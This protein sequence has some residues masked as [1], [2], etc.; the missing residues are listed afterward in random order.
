MGRWLRL[1]LAV[2]LVASGLVAIPT[3]IQTASASGSPSLTVTRTVPGNT[4][5]GETI[6]VTLSATNPGPVNGYNLSFTDIIPNGVDLSTISPAPDLIGT[7]SPRVAVWRN[8]HDLLAGT[9]QTFAYSYS[10]LASVPVSTVVAGSASAYVNSNERVVPEFD[11][12]GAVDSSTST[13]SGVSTTTSTTLVP[14]TITKS[15]PSPESELLRGIRDH[16]TAYTLTLKNNR[17][18]VSTG[19]TITDYLPAG[20]EFLGCS[21][22]DNSS[23]GI[24][25]YPGSGPITGG[26]PA[27]SNCLP[28]GASLSATTVQL[29]PDG[30]GPLPN[31]VYTR[32]EWSSLGDMA[33]GATLTIQYAAAIPLRENALPDPSGGA[34]ANLDNNTGPLTSDEEPL[35]NFVTAQAS[36]QGLVYTAS[37]T[38]QVTAEDLALQKTVQPSQVQQGQISTWTLQYRTSEYASNVGAVTFTD[39]LPDGLEY[40]DTVSGAGAPATTIQPNHTQTVVWTLSSAP[41]PNGTGSIVF[42]TTTLTNYRAGGPVAAGDSWT[43]TAN[44]SAPMDVVGAGRPTVGDQS[45]ADQTEVG[46]TVH[47]QVASRASITGGACGNGSGVSWLDNLATG[48]RPGD[49]V[50]F[51]IDVTF[52]GG[53]DTLTPIVRDVLPP[54]FSYVSSTAGPNSTVTPTSV[55]TSDP[56]AVEW[57]LP[58]VHGANTFEMIVTSVVD[59]VSA[60][61]SGADETNLVKVRYLDTSGQLYSLRDSAGVALERPVLHLTKTVD[62]GSS[63]TLIPPETAAF[64]VT[65]TNDG[66][67]AAV[68]ATVRDNLPSDWTCAD[69]VI[70]GA[71]C[72]SGVI[73]WSIASLAAHSS[74]ALDYTGTVPVTATHLDTLT[75]TAGVRDYFAATNNPAAPIMR[76]VPRNN[77][78]PSIESLANSDPAIDS[79]T[80][81]VGGLTVVKD[82]VTS[83][84]SPGNGI[85]DATIGEQVTY[86]I[87]T[88]L[89]PGL[90]LYGPATVRDIVPGGIAINATSFSINGTPGVTIVAGQTVN[91]RIVQAGSTWV[92]PPGSPDDVFVLTITGTVIDNSTNTIGTTLDNTASL[93]F[94][95]AHGTQRSVTSANAPVTIVEPQLSL[96]KSDNAGGQALPGAQVL[97]TLT[98]SN[99][100]ATSSVKSSTAYDSVVTDVVP[101]GLTPLNTASLPAG[102]G[103]T[104]LG[105]SGIWQPSNRTITF[106]N[107][108]IAPGASAQEQYTVRVDDPILSNNTLTNNAKIV[109]SSLPGSVTGERVG[110]TAN[111]QLGSGYVA[112]A[113]DTL[114]A[115]QIGVTKTADRASATIGE[116]V[117]Y[118]VTATVPANTYAPDTTL[119]DTLPSGMA[120]RSL[121]A[122]SCVDSLGA[123]CSPTISVTAP[124]GTTTN[125]VVFWVGD[126]AAQSRARTIT[127]SYTA[128]VGTSAHRPDVETNTVV[129]RFNGTNKLND[130]SL[131]GSAPNPST[132]D[133]TGN[134]ASSSVTVV[135][136][137]LVIDKNVAG[138]IGDSDTRRAKPGDPLD[139]TV[140]VTNAGTSTA[141][142]A[143]VVDTLPHQ[144]PTAISCSSDVSAITGGGSCTGGANPTISWTISSL[145]A[146]ASTSFS[147]RVT[148][149]VGWTSAQANLSGAELVNSADVTG[150]DGVPSANQLPGIGYRHYDDVTPDTVSI[151]LDLASISGTIWEDWTRNDALDP[152]DPRLAGVAVTVTYLGADG[153]PGGGDDEV[154]STVTGAGGSYSVDHLPAGNYRVSVAP[155]SLPIAGL[156]PSYDADGVSTANLWSG[157]LAE[158]EDKQHIDF[159]Y[160][161]SGSIGDAVYLD[162]NGNGFQGPRD[163]G[164]PGVGVQLVWHAPGGDLSESTTTDASGHY[165]FAN[166]PAGSYS[167]SVD[168]S[169]VPTHLTALQGAAGYQLTLPTAF[170]FLNADFGY[171]GSNT[172]GDQVFLDSNGDGVQGPSEPGIPG[173]TVTLVWAGADGQLS[174]GLDNVTFTT[175]TD[176]AG[177]YLFTGLPDGTFKVTVSG[178]PA[179]LQNTADPDGGGDSTA[180][181]SVSLGQARLDQDFGYRG[182]ASVGD[183]VWLDLSADGVGQTGA[184]GLPGIP[185]SVR[186]AGADGILGTADDIVTTATTDADGH[187]LAE[188]LPAS[189]T[190]VS[191]PASSL[192]SGI[193][194]SRDLDGGDPASTQLGLASGES[195]RD[196]DFVAV[197]RSTLHGVVWNDVDANAHRGGGEPGIAGVTVTA[198]WHGPNSSITMTGVS[199]ADG[200]WSFPAVPAGSWTVSYVPSTAPAGL[201]PTT[202]APVTV[203]VP[204]LGSGYAQFGLSARQLPGQGVQGI[205]TSLT[206]AIA[207][208]VLGLGLVLV[209]RHRRRG[210]GGN[211]E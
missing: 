185:V 11:A 54:S 70:T 175:V 145:A 188:G 28:T 25:D 109:T 17:F 85:T 86:T 55:D 105:G 167:V 118:T 74:V 176:A 50:C 62:G 120:F 68:N 111:A 53:V 47:K 67:V 16:K 59:R 43:N 98:A 144:A 27:L 58:T 209:A 159:A 48:Y 76:Y 12:T 71:S 207:L 40:L 84:T 177:G 129:L 149:P 88:R 154:Y 66:D 152:S 166:M 189:Q 127:F 36:Y 31:S 89:G 106:N 197:G 38:E 18:G 73:T 155:S 15:E 137:T 178:V 33:A 141:Y 179:G 132:F 184:P 49:I 108:S 5:L 119:F 182:T 201:K 150:Y 32:V 143:T 92:N 196:V 139:Y 44:V 22:A 61:A 94:Y 136:P 122:S 195:R 192:P 170:N 161:G 9:T 4:L 125:P 34:T 169:T 57:A 115:P 172:I 180:Q 72:S 60:A 101:A 163:P 6:T 187:Y 39:V 112:V 64:E 23:P 90:T 52:P 29:D 173:A 65:V 41:A 82:V 37:A 116:I 208:V 168:S 80:V 157:T 193:S 2:A 10:M 160:V 165:T 96:T 13:G 164:L 153:L 210:E 199:G 134:S 124:W 81:T 130:G 121:G 205:D 63:T 142:A 190:R 93:R 35:R 75:N 133:V 56:Q 186:S 146:G 19:F 69:I 26:F 79:T 162:A 42:R 20:L 183:T 77:I 113:S 135:E 117:N 114:S 174:T 194:P 202:P 103:D 181:L 46:A 110:E 200:S 21:D 87:T 95:D 1:L 126:L 171:A 148:V 8:V 123:S 99:A 102:P 128:V 191:Y 30:S 14:F 45:S 203:Q 3:G 204:A 104:V 24:E 206:I 97:Y 78:D 140:T 131:P 138:Q 211:A 198:V 51:R 156:T 151:N 83:Q 7:G 107:S 147:Y 100:A 91:G 158:N